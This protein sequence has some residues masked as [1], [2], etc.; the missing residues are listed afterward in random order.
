MTT[1]QLA[2]RWS[3]II[4]LA[5][6]AVIGAG[7]VAG[8][9]EAAFVFAIFAGLLFIGPLTTFTS[10]GYFEPDITEE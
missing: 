2:A 5:W 3:K 4:A 9:L 10:V 7:Y 6:A 8:G 1:K